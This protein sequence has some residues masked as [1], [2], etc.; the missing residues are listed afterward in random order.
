[1]KKPEVQNHD[2]VPLSGIKGTVSCEAFLAK[3]LLFI[4]A[5]YLLLPVLILF[6]FMLMYHILYILRLFSY[7]LS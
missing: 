6:V 4:L 3:N 1:M 7:S 2:T 5:L